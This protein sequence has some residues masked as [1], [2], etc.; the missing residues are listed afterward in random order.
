MKRTADLHVAGLRPLVSPRELKAQIPS[1]PESATTVLESRAA[2]TDIL[3]G[4]DSRLLAIV[5][6]CS[7]H[8]DS[9]ALEYARRLTALRR[10]TRDRLYIVM[11]V[12]FEKPR[13][14]LGWRGFIIDPHLDGT[15][16]IATGLLRARKLLREMTA[17]G[18]PTA[19]EMLDPIV[20]QYIDDLVSWAAIGA[21][22][23]ESQTHRDMAS[24]LSMP[25]GFKNNTDGN[26]Q[27]AIDGMI[28]ARD[29]HSFL[30]IDQNGAT[31]IV[32]TT[33]NP[34]THIILRGGR[35]GANFDVAALIGTA[36][37]LR[38]AGF[39][40]GFVVDCSHGNSGKNHR[41]QEIVLRSILA[42]R[43]EGV[44]GIRG[45]MIESNLVEGS[46]KL[47]ADPAD[48]AFGVSITDQCVGWEKTE[49][50]LELAYDHQ[51]EAQT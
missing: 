16:D 2:I 10:R 17:M 5:G 14:T 32:T 19:T 39:P 21:R 42:S 24:G 43:R 12:Y 28:A 15:Y 48:L 3:E 50:L 36:E 45:F 8:D 29:S 38:R 37:L 13:T 40:P 51:A 31:C 41:R 30:G 7:I 34:T 4:R 6:P 26:V 22:T 18:L 47:T 20:P 49:E 33:G 44:A 23:T 27:T 35:M 46:Q 9:A 11:R 25:V 1:G